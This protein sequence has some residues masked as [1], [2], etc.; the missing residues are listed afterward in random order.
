MSVF[1]ITF[2]VHTHKHTKVTTY[3]TVG[4]DGVS[5][6]VNKVGGKMVIVCCDRLIGSL[7]K[8]HHTHFHG[9]KSNFGEAI[10]RPLVCCARGQCPPPSYATAV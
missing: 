4:L 2:S 10:L 5:K 6:L 7:S 1:C 3:T 8:L 9:R